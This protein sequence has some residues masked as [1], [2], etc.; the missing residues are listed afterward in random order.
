LRH[1]GIE[2]KQQICAAV[3][4]IDDEKVRE[5]FEQGDEKGFARLD[6]A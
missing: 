1:S 2:G 6:A 3:Q 4:I 5:T